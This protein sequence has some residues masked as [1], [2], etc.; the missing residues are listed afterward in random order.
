MKKLTLI[1]P[2]FLEALS[3]GLYLHGDKVWSKQV[4]VLLIASWF[5]IAFIFAQEVIRRR[6]T[7]SKPLLKLLTRY[8]IIYV[9]LR[10][11]CFNY[12][13]NIAAGLRLDYIGTV[14]FIDRLLALACGGQFWMI[15]MAQG[16]C[17]IGAWFMI[18]EKL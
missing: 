12:I 7:E 10:F 17:L 1:S 2:L 11:A 13:H 15:I 3:E 18:K 5:L 6:I 8:M 9:L 4:Q 16:L 14:S